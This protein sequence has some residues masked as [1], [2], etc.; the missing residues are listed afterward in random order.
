MFFER[1]AAESGLSIRSRRHAIWGESN[2]WTAHG[3]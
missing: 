2:D 3:P 1:V